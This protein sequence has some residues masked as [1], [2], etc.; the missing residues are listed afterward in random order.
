VTFNVVVT[1][2]DAL[3]GFSY[4]NIDARSASTGQPFN[5]LAFFNNSQRTSG[6]E[7]SGTYTVPVTIP[8]GSDNGTYYLSLE[9]NDSAFNQGLYSDDPSYPGTGLIPPNGTALTFQITGGTNAPGIAI[10]QPVGTSLPAGNATVD[11]GAA[12]AGQTTSRS[13]TIRNTGTATLSSLAVEAY[14]VGNAADFA[15]GTLGATSLAPG[16]TTTFTV[17]FTPGASGARFAGISVLSNVSMA[18]ERNPFEVFLT[19]RSLTVAENWR[20]TYF[21]T[22]INSGDAADNFDYEKDG[23]PNLLEWA[24]NLNPTTASTLPAA[25]TRNGANLEFTYT[26]SLAALTAGA[27]FTVEWSDTLPGASWSTSGVSE[28]ILSNNGTVQQVKATLPAG[29]GVGRFV[30]LKVTAPP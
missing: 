17:T 8:Q 23:L 27:V 6:D 21:G 7:H 25:A 12:P 28:T 29:S 26:R 10:E 19:G 3:A 11:F 2:S 5:G 9:L 13:F 16:A 20:Q 15:I 30:H 14:P 1:I 4:G 24:C 18:A 22:A